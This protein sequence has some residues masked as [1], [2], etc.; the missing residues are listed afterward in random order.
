MTCALHLKLAHLRERRCCALFHGAC[1]ENFLR[2]QEMLCSDDADGV[3][4]AIDAAQ[5]VLA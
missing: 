4:N 3:H 1:R 5:S 2:T